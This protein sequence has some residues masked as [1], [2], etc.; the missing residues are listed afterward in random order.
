VAI[1]APLLHRGA[2]GR[3]P[4]PHAV[5]GFVILVRDDDL[6]A[7]LQEPTERLREHVGVL[8]G[9]GTE[10]HFLGAHVQVLGEPDVRGVHPLPGLAR[11]RIGIV[12]LHLESA[13]VFV[14]AIDHRAAGVGAAG[15]LEEAE[16]RERR[17]GECG[18]LS[19]NE[20][21]IDGVRHE[22][23]LGAAPALTL[24][25]SSRIEVNGGRE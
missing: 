7:R 14:Q 2:V 6:V 22:I 8:R 11:C 25:R 3:Q 12:R 21:E 19:T 18:E 23:L 13:V 1:D 9:G 4:P 16:P 17:L 24:S 10:V 5:V 20:I 15:V